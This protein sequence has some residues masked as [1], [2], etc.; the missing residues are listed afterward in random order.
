MSR[1]FTKERKKKVL[2]KGTYLLEKAAGTAWLA[3]TRLSTA[4]L[5]A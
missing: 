4:W 3:A 2:S 1:R 5:A